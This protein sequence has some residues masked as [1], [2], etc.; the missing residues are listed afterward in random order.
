MKMVP[1][2]KVVGILVLA[3]VILEV[4]NSVFKHLSI[5]F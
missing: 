1:L 5:K 3:I 4:L 2:A